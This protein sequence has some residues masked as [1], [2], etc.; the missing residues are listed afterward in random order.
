M[1]TVDL[2]PLEVEPAMVELTTLEP[3]ML[4]LDRCFAIWSEIEDIAD[5]DRDRTE[6]PFEEWTE[7]LRSRSATGDFVLAFSS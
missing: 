6:P 7:I 4:R 3:P 5:G 1:L 2:G